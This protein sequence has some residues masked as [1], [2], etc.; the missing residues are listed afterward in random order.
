[1]RW[2]LALVLVLAACG[3]SAGTPARSSTLRADNPVTAPPSTVPAAAAATSP[4]TAAAAATAA[5]TAAG[6]KV[7]HEQLQN[8][9][10]TLAEMPTGWTQSATV[11]GSSTICG[12]QPPANRLDSATVY[13]LK[14]QVGPALGESLSLYPS[15]AAAARMAQIQQQVNCASFSDTSKATPTSYTVSPLS[16]PKLGD[17][18][19]AVRVTDTDVT[20]L[21]P[22]QQDLVYFRVGDVV[23]TVLYLSVGTIDSTQTEAFARQA[24]AKVRKL[25]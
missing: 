22:L 9:L 5:T 24:E 18:T 21:G 23:V 14:S 1:M 16:F 2:C 4:G 6:A 13:F 8:A 25:S 19:Y 10:L 17:E 11:G 15:G 12:L 20:L 3:S 7:N